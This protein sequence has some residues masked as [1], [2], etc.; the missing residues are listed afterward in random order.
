[1]ID[2]TP[3]KP[4]NV[5]PYPFPPGMPESV[6][7]EVKV[8]GTPVFVH[9]TEVA[10]VALF[11]VRGACE[12]RVTWNRD[13]ESAVVRPL[14]R[15]IEPRIEGRTVCF[16][17]D[18]PGHLCLEVND[19]ISR[20]LFLFVD[21]PE[22]DVPAPGVEGV[23]YF[24]G[25]RIHEVGELRVADGET[26]YLAP[27]AVLHGIVRA[28]GASGIRIR[29]RGILDGRVREE[30]TRFVEVKNCAG[31]ELR[32]VLV[33][34]SF[35]W[36]VVPWGCRDVR[37]CNTK[38]FSWRAN[39]D[40]LDICSCRD[41]VVEDCFFRTLDDCIAVKAPRGDRSHDAD[42]DGVRIRRSVFWNAEWGNAMEIGF[43]LR[44]AR[45]G[46]I[47][48]ED[49]DIIRV[50][51]GAVFSVHNGDWAEVEDVRFENIRVEDA[52]DKLLDLHVALSIYSRDCPER[53][54]RGNHDRVPTGEGQWVP[55]SVL[56]D[57]EAAATQNA[58]GAI[59]RVRLK[60]ITLLGDTL[61]RSQIIG[62]SKPD[63]I[64]DVVVENLCHRGRRIATAGES[65]LEVTDA[66]PVVFQD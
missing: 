16:T 55:D 15:H 43:E 3:N 33:L 4:A 64:R 7:C 12:V 62:C 57:E 61:P 21:P 17:V 56:T 9:R 52:R 54:H 53:Y 6:D 50:E 30:K 23:R 1:M 2:T 13:I 42:V 14:S 11:A 36:T 41:V 37:L 25:G 8:D 46:D 51:R 22:T 18:G 27:G 26:V 49:C 47:V 65:G 29:G 31:V 59:R 28:D 58:R 39:D 45:I 19:D 34:G 38:I 24:E 5:I 10:D 60:D 66:P 35:G 32:D 20:P 44:T 40:G 63:A 48:W